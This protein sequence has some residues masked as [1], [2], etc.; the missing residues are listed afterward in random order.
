MVGTSSERSVDEAVA[1]ACST[2]HGCIVERQALELGMTKHQIEWRLRR[3]RW[4][5][6]MRGVYSIGG[7]PP[8]WEQRAFAA[9]EWAGPTAALSHGAAAR[10]WRVDG[11]AD[12]PIR[13]SVAGRRVRPR[14]DFQVDNVDDRLVAQ[15]VVIDRI[16]VTSMKR[17]LLDLAAINDPRFEHALDQ[18]IRRR[19]DMLGQ[20][21]LML[22]DA[23]AARRRGVKVLHDAIAER[24]PGGAPSQVDLADTLR[25][26]IRTSPLPLPEPEHPVRLPTGVIHVDL[27]YP[28]A[29]LAIECDGYAWHMDRASFERDRTRDAE[30]MALG[31]R[32]LRFTWAQI[33]FRPAWVL[34]QV[35][36]RLTT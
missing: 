15:I 10:M 28:S 14:P 20:L 29:R 17:M 33:T 22:E 13:I 26:L 21:T 4:R 34:E 19:R 12:D 24:L 3:G 8:T 30:L 27:A 35:R 36:G 11:F 23:W 16:R 32:V 9:S 31:W 1:R 18:C 25:R 5:R 2:R 6:L 7:A